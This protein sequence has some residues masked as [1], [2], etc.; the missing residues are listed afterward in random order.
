MPVAVRLIEAPLAS[1]LAALLC[2]VWQKMLLRVRHPKSSGI[3]MDGVTYH[4]ASQWPGARFMAG[5]TWSPDKQ[6]AP[7]KLVALSHLL[8]QYTEATDTERRKLV[9]A[10]HQAAAWFGVLA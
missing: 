6:T 2:A 4:F 3:G 9:G 7:G 10:I 1:E 8:C 5:M